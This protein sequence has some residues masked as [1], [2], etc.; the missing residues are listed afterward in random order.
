MFHQSATYN[1]VESPKIYGT[2]NTRI[3]YPFCTCSSEGAANCD[4]TIESL[5]GYTDGCYQ[6]F[7]RMYRRALPK[8]WQKLN[9]TQRHTRTTLPKFATEILAETKFFIEDTKAWC[10]LFYLPIFEVVL[11]FHMKFG[12]GTT[13]CAT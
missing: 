13:K 12:K 4:G 5:T 2:A 6:N 9:S 10:Y 11:Q 1:V 8:F 3:C 7:D